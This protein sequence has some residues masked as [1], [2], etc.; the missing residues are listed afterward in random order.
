MEETPVALFISVGAWKK[1]LPYI[2]YG[3]NPSFL[4][5]MLLTYYL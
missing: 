4:A 5:S 3:K 1:S 2:P